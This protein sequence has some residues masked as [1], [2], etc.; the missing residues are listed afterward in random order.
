MAVLAE[1]MERVDERAA[2]LGITVGPDAVLFTRSP[3]GSQPLIPDTATQRHD[4]MAKRLGIKPPLHKLRHYSATELIAA[5]QRPNYRR[6]PRPW[7]R[8]NHPVKGLCRMGQR[9][10]SARG[11]V[12]RRTL[13]ATLE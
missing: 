2:S 6:A 11:G 9:S 1:Y 8:R 5:S 4:R 13:T 3:D 7:P 12:A 10:R